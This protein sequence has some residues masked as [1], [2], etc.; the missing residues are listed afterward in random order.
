MTI[1]RRELGERNKIWHRAT[2]PFIPVSIKKHESFPPH[3]YKNIEIIPVDSSFFASSISLAADC[4]RELFLLTEK[5]SAL[6]V[7]SSVLK[8]DDFN[9]VENIAYLVRNEPHRKCNQCHG[10]PQMLMT[11]PHVSPINYLPITY[12]LSPDRSLD[13]TIIFTLGLALSV[14]LI[15]IDT[16]VAG[17]F[18]GSSTRDRTGR[19]DWYIDSCEW[20]GD[21]RGAKHFTNDLAMPG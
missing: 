21:V 4:C 9:R 12:D 15:G 7:K 1:W 5:C 8:N 19:S 2:T 6:Y 3:H 17:T 16:T 18:S 14:V 11:R 13:L 20:G 10:L